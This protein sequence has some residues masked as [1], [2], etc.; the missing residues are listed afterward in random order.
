LQREFAV[1]SGEIVK[2]TAGSSDWEVTIDGIAQA[3]GYIG[4]TVNVKIP[5]TQKLVSGLLTA[6]GVVEVR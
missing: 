3:S 4:D 5:R 6:K 1:K 2:V